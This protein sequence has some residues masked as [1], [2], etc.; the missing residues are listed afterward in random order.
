MRVINA[1]GEAEE[2]SVRACF[3]ELLSC[4]VNIVRT[5]KRRP[6]QLTAAISALTVA[7]DGAD[8]KA[9]VGTGFLGLMEDFWQGSGK[10][11]GW[12]SQDVR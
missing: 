2:Q 7:M 5:S 6:E 9:L 4:L 11:S 10:A 8:L 1:S 12:W 3:Q